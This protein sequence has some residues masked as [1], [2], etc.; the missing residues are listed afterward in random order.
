MQKFLAYILMLVGTLA[1]LPVLGETHA[2][3]EVVQYLSN[4]K[5][6]SRQKA[7]LREI[8]QDPYFDSK[9]ASFAGL[10]PMRFANQATETQA[11]FAAQYIVFQEVSRTRPSAESLQFARQNLKRSDWCSAVVKSWADGQTVSQV[12]AYDGLVSLYYVLSR[13]MELRLNALA[14]PAIQRDAPQAV[15]P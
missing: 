13:D 1:V 11:C 3:D 9:V 10:T 12:L 2:T 14:N 6:T 5:L 15:R 4:P 8:A 7:L